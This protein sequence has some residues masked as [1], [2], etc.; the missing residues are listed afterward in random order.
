MRKHYIGS[1]QKTYTGQPSA[2]NK[3]SYEMTGY[4]LGSQPFKDLSSIHILHFYFII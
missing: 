1:S 3:E 4:T 2:S